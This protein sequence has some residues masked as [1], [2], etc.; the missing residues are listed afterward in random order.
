M[1]E[2]AASLGG[3]IEVS[4]GSRGGTRVQLTFPP[5]DAREEEPEQITMAQ[6][7]MARTIA[8]QTR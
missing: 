3:V 4:A 2:R 6:T 1:R 5:R 7:N 8:A